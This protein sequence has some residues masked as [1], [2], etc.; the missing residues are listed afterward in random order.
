MGQAHGVYNS[1][2]KPLR[3]LNFAVSTTKGRGDN[4]DLG[5][6][7]V[8]ASLDPIPQFV[9][10]QLKRESLR[11]NGSAYAG[12][13][14]LYR[15]LLG[16][17]VFST[18]W[19]HVD[20]LVIPAGS[21]AT[22]KQPSDLEEVFYVVKGAGSISIPSDSA[23][24]KM[25]DAFFRSPAEALTITNKGKDDLELLVIGVATAKQNGAPRSGNA[26]AP[27]AI[28]LQMDFVVA[29][30][31]REA[32]EK[33][34]SSLYVPA[35]TVQQGYLG[36]KML[37]LFPDNIAKEIQAEP[38]TYNYQI[39][40]SFDTEEARRK[41]VASPQHQVAWPAAS[42]LA[43]EYKWRGYDVVGDDNK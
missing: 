33:M 41:W 22:S 29:R 25:D 14:V 16:P 38:T 2:G 1:S 19:H 42:A 27:K 12:T 18:T 3:W 4:F 32:F 20:H 43:K 8:G 26:A 39:Q 13:G 24:V 7:R 21:T 31:N 11:S 9:S 34:Y 30:E 6:D 17:D 40:I 36:S 10:G 28:V 5:D 23:A 37:R 35:M 15:R